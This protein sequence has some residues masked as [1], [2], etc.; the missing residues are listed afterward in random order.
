MFKQLAI[1]V[2]P[3]Q[4]KQESQ[5]VQ[6]KSEEEKLEAQIAWAKRNYDYHH[7]R[8]GFMVRDEFWR[9]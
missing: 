1:K 2:E 9:W 7:E 5:P 8:L 6:P 4:N 3:I